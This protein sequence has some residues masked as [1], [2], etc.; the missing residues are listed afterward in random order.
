MKGVRRAIEMLINDEWN[1]D[2]IKPGINIMLD[3]EG[4]VC[5]IAGSVVT[6]ERKDNHILLR[7]AISTEI[8]SAAYLSIKE[9]IGHDPTMRSAGREVII[10][11][12]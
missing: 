8:L 3:R 9:L 12:S 7:G 10:Y 6:F 1:D 11:V 5:Q 2:D 4:K